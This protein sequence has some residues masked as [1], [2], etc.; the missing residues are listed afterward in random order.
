MPTDFQLHTPIAFFIYRRPDLTARVFEAIRQVRPSQL[1]IIA[2]GP[3]PA[4][5]QEAQSCETTRE[6]VR[7]IDWDCQVYTDFSPVNLGL[8]KRISS[9]LDWVFSQVDQAIILEDDCLPDPSFFL[10]CQALL[11]HYAN[12]QRIMTISGDNYQFGRCRTTYSYYFSRYNHCWGWATWQRAW[13]HF[14]FDMSQWPTV[15]DQ[16]W[17]WDILQDRAAVK[18]WETAFQRTF[19]GIYDTWDYRWTLACWLRSGLT[20][21]PQVNLVSNIGFGTAGTHLVRRNIF[22]DL[23]SGAVTFPLKH[24]PYVIRDARADRYTQNVLFSMAPINR[25]RR[26]FGIGL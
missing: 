23:A 12:D 15:R 3:H 21:L 16:G 13:Q 4:R 1:L 18:V 2:D 6:V 20:V 7:S 5:P 19:E 9:G 25:I 10:F 22:A 11:N 26:K 17:L 24:P 14:D 8:A